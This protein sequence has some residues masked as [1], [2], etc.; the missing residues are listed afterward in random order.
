MKMH[1]SVAA[2]GRYLTHTLP[3]GKARFARVAVRARC[4]AAAAALAIWSAPAAH[5]DGKVTWGS[6]L[7]GTQVSANAATWD[8]AT[9]TYTFTIPAGKFYAFVTTTFVPVT[10]TIPSSGF[11]YATVSFSMNASGAM[12]TGTQGERRFFMGLFNTNGTAP[13]AVGNFTDDYG[14][15]TDLRPNTALAS[16]TGEGFAALQP[17]A[18]PPA[19]STVPAN[20][21][22]N[23]STPT[24]LGGTTKIISGANG[25]AGTVSDNQLIDARFR[26]AMSATGGVSLGSG[27]TAATAGVLYIDHTENAKTS[28][29]DAANTVTYVGIKTS[30]ST[31][32]TLGGPITFNEF[33]FSFNN[34]TASDVTFTLSALT[35]NGVPYFTPATGQPPATLTGTTGQDISIS[36]TTIG[37][38]VTYQWQKSTDGGA[39]FTAIDPVANPSAATATLSLTAAT[40][41]NDG[42]YRV[43]AGNAAGSVTSTDCTLTLSAA[44]VGPSIQTDP[45]SATI[46][47][48]GSNTFSVGANGTAPLTY[49]WSKSTDAGANYVDIPN[50]TDATYT[51]SSAQL[52]D[53]ALYRAVVTNSVGTATS[54]AATL[55]VNQTPSFTTQPTGGNLNPGDNLALT[56][57]AAGTPTPA[58]QWKLNNVVISGATNATYTITG[59]TGANAGQYTVVATNAA[60]SSTSSTATVTVLSPSLTTASL[61]PAN[62]ATAVFPDQPLAI[63][64]SQA[65]SPGLT[66]NIK[67]YDAASPATPVDTINFSAASVRTASAAQLALPVQSQ[68][69]GGQA[70]MNYYPVTVSGNTLKIF[71]R[72]GSLTY[73]KTYYVTIDVGAIVD[74]TGATFAGFTSNTTW[75]FTTKAAGPADGATTLT[76]ANDG[77][78]D[79]YTVQGA[80]DFI[81]ANNVTPITIHI[82]N[83]T[84]V[85]LVSWTNKSNLTFLGESRAG[86]VIGYANNNNFNSS[87]TAWRAAFGCRGG[88]TGTVIANLSLKNFTAKTGSQAETLYLSGSATAMQAIITNVNLSSYQDT[89]LINGQAYISDSYIEGDTDFMWGAGPVYFARCELKA[90][91]IQSHY[92]Q[93]RNPATNHGFVYSNC[94]WD[95]AAGD[96]QNPA[97][98]ITNSDLGRLD[99]NANPHTEVVLL[100]CL[101]GDHI[102]PAGWNANGQ[103]TPAGTALTN[104]VEYN[105]RKISDNTPVDVS[106]RISWSYQWTSPANDTQIAHFSDATWALNTAMDGTV[107]SSWTPALAPIIVSQPAAASVLNGTGASFTVGAVGVP[108]ATYQWRKGGVDISGATGASFTIAS[109][110]ADDAGDYTVVVTNASGSV[111]SGVATLAVGALPTITT[112][113]VA[114]QGVAAGT[115][116]TFNIAATG[117]ALTYQWQKDGVDVAGATSATLTLANPRVSDAGDY[118]VIVTSAAG[119]VTSSAGHLTVAPAGGLAWQ[120]YDQT[121]ARLSA[122]A[123]AFD[124]ATNTYTFTI[125]ANSTVTLVTSSFVPL[126]LSKPTTGTNNLPVT[127]SMLAS[128]G[129]GTGGSNQF[130]YTGFGLF[131]N[132]GTAPAAA[133]NFTDDKGLW[134]E[135]YQSTGAVSMKPQSVTSGTPFCPVSLFQSDINT[136]Y[137]MGTGTGGALGTV[138]DN[139][140]VDMIVRPSAAASGTVTIGTNSNAVGVSGG[141]LLDHATGGLVLNRRVYSSGSTGLSVASASITFNEFGYHFQNSTGAAV[142]LQLGNFAGITTVPYFT[143][144]PQAHG[145]VAVGDSIT[146]TAVAAGGATTYQWQISTDGG[147]NFTNI[148]STANASAATA[149]LT[150]GNV[151]L[152]GAATYQLVASNAAGSVTSVRTKLEVASSPFAPVIELQ[153]ASATKLAGAAYTLKVT[154]SASAPVTYQWKKNGNPIADATNPTLVFATL[155][156]ADAGDYSVVVTNGLAS[157]TSSVATLVVQYVPVITTQ[158]TGDNVNAGASVT[159]SVAADALPTATYQWKKNDVAISGATG[160]SYTIASAAAADTGNY[161]VVVTNLA[162]NVTSAVA[163]VNVLSGSLAL[164]G[165]S[166]LRATGAGAYPETPIT[167]DFSAPIAAGLNGAIKIYD[168]ASPGTP[169]DTISFSSAT[170]RTATAAI[171]ALPT[172]AKTIGT[173]A[174]FN[175]YPVTISG[176]TATIYPT[177][178]ALTYGKSYYVTI[179]PGVFVDSTGLAFAGVSSNSTIAFTTMSAAPAA[180]TTTLTVAKDGSG[181]FCTVQAALDWVPAANTTP[182]R[183]AI[184]DG[185]YYEIVYWTAKDQLTIVGQSRTGTIVGYPNNNTLNPQGT[186][187]RA[188]FEGRNSTGTVLANLTVKN[189]TAFGGS[190]AEAVYFN[191]ADTA[192]TT[193]ASVNLSSFQDTLNVNGPTYVSDSYI[194][195]D[196]DFMWGNGPVFFNNCELKMLHSTTFYTQVRNPATNHGFVYS[197]C[198]F[199]ADTGVTGSY[200]G[201]LNQNAPAYTEVVLLNCREADTALNPLGWDPNGIADRSNTLCVE[202]NPT[203]QSDGTP[204]AVTGRVSW[205]FQWTSPANDAQVANYS[206]PTWVL[207]TQ[208]D[209]TAKATPTNWTPALAPL[210]AT[211][212][213]NSAVSAG[214]PVSLTV[215]VLAVPSPTYQWKKNGVAIPGAISATYSIPSADATSSGG[216]SVTVTNAAGSATSSIAVVSVD[217]VIGFA[218]TYFGQFGA[219]G[220]WALS[221]RGDNTGTFIGYLPQRHSAIV[222]DVIINADGSFTV[223]GSEIRP[224]AVDTRTAAS[225]SSS[226]GSDRLGRATGVTLLGQI[227]G[228]NVTGS[229]DGIDET[230]AGSMDVPTGGL[231]SLA[232]FYTASA[233]GTASGT[234][235]VIVGANG[236]AVIVTTAATFVGGGTGVVDSTGHLTVTASDS[237]K[238]VITIDAEKQSIAAAVTPA[239]SSTVISFAGVSESVPSIRRFVNT[240]TRSF[241]GAG[242]HVLIVGFVIDGPAP[243]QILLRAVG[244]GL[245]AQGVSGVLAQP[246]IQLHHGA[247]VLDENAGW[248]TAPNHADIASVASATGAFALAEGSR[249]AAL[250]VT[251]DPGVYSAVVSGADGGTGVAL[252]EIYEAPIPPTDAGK[253]VNISGRGQIGADSNTLIAGFVISGNTTKQVLIRAVGPGIKPMGVDDA[254]TGVKL[255]LFHNSAVIASN[256]KWGSAATAPAVVTA[257]SATGAF[258]LADGSGDSALLVTLEPGIY[259]VHATGVSGATGVALIEVY[260][261]P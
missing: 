71:P 248:S 43:V 104:C 142:T 155:T 77:S 68:T 137:G 145:T 256:D 165:S 238:F 108:A 40:S 85:E 34:T 130:H 38:G 21:L 58:Y 249:D 201:R 220:N 141:V 252:A 94:T 99:Q 217:G 7:A 87:G 19:A 192:Q 89:L 185:T 83:G 193:I 2:L 133:G 113:P 97:N 15:W 117:S 76:V 70:G 120:S 72:N 180:G 56:A 166:V 91:S 243:K 1:S 123:A 226:G 134:I 53:A 115:P 44:A 253:L 147:A 66:G 171:L 52:S 242:N 132:G 12:S 110:A 109:A 224:L 215:E 247:T 160:S 90:L 140:L 208:K 36:V 59:A 26:V 119:S 156:P 139:L 218:G 205:S 196:T 64:F 177:N 51:V 170:A 175:Y 73:N 174:G 13:A 122:D 131:N 37:T 257:A 105:S 210:I 151:Q 255:S 35:L 14:V 138:N 126:V 259:S 234:T 245:T 212:P 23:V 48:G 75:T 69:I 199:S 121:G 209:G 107:S 33:G 96:S 163:S 153:P 229:I 214:Q 216:Y 92:T 39:N 228:G 24:Q 239:G 41:A 237:T 168:A 60:G 173:L 11:N 159:L 258:P 231:P 42:I 161:T 4:L 6:Y 88:S 164:S 227:T 118:T 128:G 136:P 98:P 82:K 49:Q 5:A 47:V 244:P 222:L 233:V 101:L 198:L 235:Y 240:S 232:G 3:S 207:N 93:V 16:V 190:Q 230:F 211:Q 150:L 184:K 103:S 124:P 67:I 78:G 111:T 8:P 100:N 148:D 191:N 127:F 188:A 202:F 178:G 50:A 172:K 176:S 203:K 236:D 54:A 125:A 31:T 157:V 55:S 10:L 17:L 241:V 112:Q 221:V 169:V 213:A 261:V 254:V 162:G 102:I 129:Y 25:G 65:I 63:T 251:L 46:L 143:T 182:T 200:L 28:F 179:D 219:G 149:A 32:A 183:I 79:F 195:G 181:D 74:S 223:T 225:I 62:N 30:A 84:Y 152:A 206:N 167:L 194:E 22:V 29:N 20:L 158:P 144:Q 186:N 116:V 18:T 81:P 187:G 189:F 45:Q 114:A 57:A 260:E 106:G 61:L 135:F 86:V 80:L 95:A 146:L 9:A 246:K 27:V 197:N 250:L 154:A 204:V